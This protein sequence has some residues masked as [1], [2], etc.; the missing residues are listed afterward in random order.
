M[1]GP[2]GIVYATD[3]DP[4]SNEAIGKKERSERTRNPSLATI[5]PL[6][7]EH[8]RDSATSQLE[9]ESVDVVLIIL[10]AVFGRSDDARNPAETKNADL[11][12]LKDFLRIMKPGGR[13]YYHIDWVRSGMLPLNEA[14]ALFAEAGFHKEYET[15]PLPDRAPA[16]T[17]LLTP[18]GERMDLKRGFI[19]VFRK[20]EK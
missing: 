2:S 20:P 3:I 4:K 11:T 6:L 9:P 13:F 17:F 15:L 18:M 19:A 16:E 10:S 5:K 7:C 14:A 8:P 1:V 12:Y